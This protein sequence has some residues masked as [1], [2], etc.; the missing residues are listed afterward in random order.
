[1]ENLFPKLVKQLE[2]TKDNNHK[3]KQTLYDLEKDIQGK[4]DPL[5]SKTTIKDIRS[6]V[7]L[8]KL[9]KSK[10]GPVSNEILKCNPKVATLCIMFSFVLESQIFPNSWNLSLIKPLYKSGPKTKHGNYREICISSHL[11][12]LFT[13]VL[14]KDLKNGWNLIKDFTG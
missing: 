8:L 4:L 10:F 3:V 14:N 9:G 12:K 1:M 5:H 2:N 13:C 7:K 6:V 11:P